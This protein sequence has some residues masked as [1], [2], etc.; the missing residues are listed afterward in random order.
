MNTTRLKKLSECADR[1]LILELDAKPQTVHLSFNR[2]SKRLDVVIEMLKLLKKE[3]KNI[4]CPDL[5]TIA[6]N[7]TI[8]IEEIKFV[9]N[10]LMPDMEKMFQLIDRLDTVDF[11][12]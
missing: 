3:A 10:T 11:E 12:K 5:Y 1:A 9:Q 8:A 4:N 6:Y 2:C 7:T